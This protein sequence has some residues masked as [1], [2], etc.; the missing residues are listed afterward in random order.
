MNLTRLVTTSE[1]TLQASSLPASRVYK[2]V[3]FT[4]DYEFQFEWYGGAYIDV[5]VY[6]Q[7]FEVINVWNSADDKPTIKRSM[8]AFSE[9]VVE[10]VKD[11]EASDVAA[12]GY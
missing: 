8:D 1:A 2:A 7:P 6:G 5:A 4:D 11:Y 3:A 9:R 10:W 12:A